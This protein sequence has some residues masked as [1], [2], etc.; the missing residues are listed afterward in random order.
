MG[1][2]PSDRV[3]FTMCRPRAEYT[4]FDACYVVGAQRANT[5][6]AAHL[7]FLLISPR[8]GQAFTSSEP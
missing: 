7:V 1:V 2:L 8:H 3:G 4:V 6:E 5:R